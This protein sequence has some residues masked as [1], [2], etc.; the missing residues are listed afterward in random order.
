MVMKS[1]LAGLGPLVADCHSVSTG[2]TSS[3]VMGQPLIGANDSA[4]RNPMSHYRRYPYLASHISPTIMITPHSGKRT[5]PTT[6][7]KRRNASYQFRVR[8]RPSPPP[9]GRRPAHSLLAHIQ[10][11]SGKKGKN[12]RCGVYENKNDATF[13][14][15]IRYYT[16]LGR[17]AQQQSHLRYETK[18]GTLLLILVRFLTDQNYP[19]QPL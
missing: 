12:A 1:F 16:F 17:T 14:R 15:I 5:F 18:D 4:N 11:W 8:T 19:A 2:R 10:P 3:V 13:L 6:P 9:A 7:N